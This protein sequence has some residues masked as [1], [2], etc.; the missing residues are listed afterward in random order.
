MCCLKYE[1]EQY[2]RAKK[3]L[4]NVGKEAITP[5][6]RGVVVEINV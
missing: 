1:Q 2:E 4:P 5:D 3:L 6:G